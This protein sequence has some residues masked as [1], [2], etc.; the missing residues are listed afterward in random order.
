VKSIKPEII[1]L[2][3]DEVNDF[4]P[5]SDLSYCFINHSFNPLFFNLQKKW[6]NLELFF[7]I[8]DTGFLPLMLEN[9]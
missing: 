2:T 6:K 9:L 8:D 4:K 3:A 1:G 5:K 7:R